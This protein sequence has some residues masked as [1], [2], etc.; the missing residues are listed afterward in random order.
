MVNT[1]SGPLFSSKLFRVTP[2]ILSFS[3]ASGAVGS[4]VTIAGAGLIQTEKITVG[5][6]QVTAYTVNSDSKLTFTVPTGAKSGAIAL[7]TPGGS[8]SKQT[9]TVT[10]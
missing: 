3:P 1:S 8:A 5:G 9:F 2:K 10:P 7:T 6:V 4:A